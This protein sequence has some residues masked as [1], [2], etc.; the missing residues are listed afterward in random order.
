MTG[1]ITRLACY[2]LPLIHS[3]LLRPD[4]VITTDTPSFHQVLRILKQQIDAELPVVEDSLEI[5]DVAR[6]YL[7]DREFRLMNARKAT[8]NSPLHVAKTLSAPQQQQSTYA[9]L[10]AS[11]PVQVT[12]SSSYDPFKRNDAKRKSISKSFTSMFS[13]KSSGKFTF[14]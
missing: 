5:I 4:I 1:L 9:H 3:I 13:R 6:S 7:I 8:E 10:S 11:S 2:P 14:T 12:P